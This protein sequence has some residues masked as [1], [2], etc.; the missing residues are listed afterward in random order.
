MTFP[1]QKKQIVLI[2]LV[3]LTTFICAYFVNEYIN[4]SIDQT[5]ENTTYALEA[6]I[7][8]QELLLNSIADLTRQLGADEITEQI[9]VDC[10]PIERERFD[11]LLGQLSSNI[12]ITDLRELDTLFY[13]CGSYYADRKSVMAARLIREV[14]VYRDY[15]TLRDNIVGNTESA[16]ERADKWQQVATMELELAEDFNRLV[17]LQ[18]EII[19]TLLAGKSRT[20]PEIEATLLEVTETRNTMT[21]KTQQIERIRAELRSV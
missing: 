2:T 20:S 21:V 7:A 5:L 15:L 16:N 19:L 11:T 1:I 14:A 3:A 18:G 12:S 9:V 6:H 10:T 8:E 4:R 17:E 13:K